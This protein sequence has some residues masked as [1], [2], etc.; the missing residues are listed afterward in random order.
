MSIKPI[1]G[2]CRLLLLLGRW[3]D[4]FFFFFVVQGQSLGEACVDILG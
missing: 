3:K 2:A 1:Q 4:G